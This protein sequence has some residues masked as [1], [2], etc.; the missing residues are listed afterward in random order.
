MK[1]QLLKEYQSR[2]LKIPTRQVFNKGIAGPGYSIKL[3]SNSDL[4]EKITPLNKFAGTFSEKDD[5]FEEFGFD[6]KFFYR[7]EKYNTGSNTPELAEI[8]IGYISE[9]MDGEKYIERVKPLAI[10]DREGTPQPITCPDITI[11]QN[12]DGQ[13]TM[14]SAFFPE[15]IENLFSDPH[16]IIASSPYAPAVPVYV[17]ENTFIGRKKGDVESINI[18]YLA[19]YIT[20]L[21]KQL[22]FKAS[23]L[24]SNILKCKSLQLEPQSKKAEETAGVI[25]FDKDTSQL[26]YYD[27]KE[28]RVLVSQSIKG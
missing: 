11:A 28:W 20:S 13:T 10:L 25:Y 7:A 18:S 24:I 5:F 22:T 14:I 6:N 4:C 1:P 27:G 19:E 3:A 16:I 8:G 15:Q 17:E 9:H 2:K 21:T 23:K 12:S 26:R